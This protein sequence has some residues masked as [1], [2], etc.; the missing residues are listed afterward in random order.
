MLS[1][2]FSF[3]FS[4]ISKSIRNQPIQTGK[5]FLVFYAGKE[6]SAAYFLKM[7]YFPLRI[8]KGGLIPC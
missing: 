5:I 7:R 2:S 4:R 3:P 1:C 8:L 6:G